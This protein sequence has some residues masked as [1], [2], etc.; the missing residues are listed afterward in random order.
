[1]TKRGYNLNIVKRD[2]MSLWPMAFEQKT[3]LQGNKKVRL[4]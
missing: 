4:K 1:M 2:S 3:G